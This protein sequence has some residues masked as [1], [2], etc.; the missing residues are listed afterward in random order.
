MVLLLLAHL[1]RLPR[2]VPLVMVHPDPLP[3]GRLQE[4]R[5]DVHALRP[6]ARI[7]LQPQLPPGLSPLPPHH[8][9]PGP[10]A[11]A[12]ARN[13]GQAPASS[14]DLDRG[15]ERSCY[16]LELHIILARR[17]PC[18]LELGPVRDSHS[19]MGHLVA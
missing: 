13:R 1:L 15:R 11:D 17:A 12:P 19:R 18:F 10:M 6:P 3:R 8:R 4:P 2:L 9:R 5:T 16:R 14:P 7:P